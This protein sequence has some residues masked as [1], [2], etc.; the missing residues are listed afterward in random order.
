MAIDL[1]RLCIHT[2]TTRDWELEKA[3]EKYVEKGIR[4]ISVWRNYLE[5]RNLKD[6]KALLASNKMNVVSLVRGGF[7]T[8]LNESDRV[9]AID[10]NKKAIEE[11]ASIGA[12]MVVLVCGASPG[13]SLEVSRTQIQ[14]GIE[15]ILPMAMDLEVKLAIEPLH[16]MYADTRSAV[17][18]LN[19]ANRMAETIDS[20]YVGVAIDVDHLWWDETLKQEILRCGR[21][22]NIFAFHLCDW[23]NPTRDL[24][25]DRTIM[26]EG[27]IPIQ[28]IINMVREAGFNGFNEVEIFSD[29]HWAEDQD[30]FLEKII[31]AYMR[32]KL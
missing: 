27:V 8:G 28:E 20:E 25:N 6:V 7:F 5:S 26:G 32:Y 10:E 14:R 15:S 18:T 21:N 29:E 12:E 22:N 13:Q 11:A 19:Q 2:I 16:P 3:V 30:D 1:S 23:R 9:K 4:G 24:L 31:R 17:N